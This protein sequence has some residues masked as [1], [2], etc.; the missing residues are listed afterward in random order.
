M[1]L[2]NN[3]IKHAQLYAI[4]QSFRPLLHIF[5]DQLHNWWHLKDTHLV[6][7][8]DVLIQWWESAMMKM[9][10]FYFLRDVSKMCSFFLDHLWFATRNRK[11]A[12]M[13]IS[14]HQHR[15]VPKSVFFGRSNSAGHPNVI[16]RSTNFMTA[17]CIWDICGQ[18]FLILENDRG[19]RCSVGGIN[20]VVILSTIYFW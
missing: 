17:F 7:G 1:Q 11:S 12:T 4:S 3:T 16:R 19:V 5:G 14:H 20:T 10:P 8:N 18:S 6:N 15:T 9:L 2:P 13:H